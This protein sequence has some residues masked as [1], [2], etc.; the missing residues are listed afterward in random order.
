MC[1]ERAC[2]CLVWAVSVDNPRAGDRDIARASF[3]GEE[4]DISGLLVGRILVK[5]ARKLTAIPVWCQPPTSGAHKHG[6]S[7]QLG[8]ACNIQSPLIKEA[9]I[10]LS[11]R[12]PETASQRTSES[13]RLSLESAIYGTAPRK[14]AHVLNLG[15][16]GRYREE[17]RGSR[18]IQVPIDIISTSQEV[19]K[20]THTCRACTNPCAVRSTF[21]PRSAALRGTKLQTQNARIQKAGMNIICPRVPYAVEVRKRLHR[22]LR[23]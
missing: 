4:R 18:V 20:S 17:R 13:V 19:E 1:A 8:S 7:A 23:R 10:S 16:G 12:K 22:E 5:T 2:V 9:C 11:I 21:D 14:E 15:G 6:S 3:A